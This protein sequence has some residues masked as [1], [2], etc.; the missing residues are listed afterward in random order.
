MAD[1]FSF[2]IPDNFPVVYT[3]DHPALEPLRARGEVKLYSTRHQSQDELI[4]RMRGAT[5]VLNVRAYSKFTPE[6]F[7]SLYA[8]WDAH[9]EKALVAL[10]T[11]YLNTNS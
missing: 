2:S 5:A 10:A 7:A 9:R 3:E 8:A 6:V 4:D 11:S 1:R